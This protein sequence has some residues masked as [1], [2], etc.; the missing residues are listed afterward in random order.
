MHHVIHQYTKLFYKLFFKKS[1]LIFYEKLAYVG[2]EWPW[3][4][5]KIIFNDEIY[6][7]EY[8]HLMNIFENILD[9][10]SLLY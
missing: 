2:D 9:Y 3:K 7:L 4:L 1:K 6:K 8:E 10:M 5:I